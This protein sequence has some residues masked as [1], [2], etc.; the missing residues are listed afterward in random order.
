[1]TFEQWPEEI[2][3][4]LKPDEDTYAVLLTHDPKIDDQALHLLL[5]SN[6]AY[7]GALGSKRT[8]EKRINRLLKAG[9]TDEE[10][11]KIHGPVGVDIKAKKPKEV[12]LSIIGEVIKT[13]NRFL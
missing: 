5:K 1:M 6:A 9:F 8:H 3:P 2:L 13:R 4:D 11:N 12:A 10:I 7:I